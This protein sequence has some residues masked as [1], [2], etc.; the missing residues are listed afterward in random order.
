MVVIV[1]IKDDVGYLSPKIS[2]F[3]HLPSYFDG[4]LYI[5]LELSYWRFLLHPSRASR[6]LTYF[7]CHP[8][9]RFQHFNK[10]EE[11]HSYCIE[12]DLDIHFHSLYGNTI[13]LL[14]VRCSEDIILF[15]IKIYSVLVCRCV[16]SASRGKGGMYIG[17]KRCLY[18]MVNNIQVR[19]LSIFM[20]EH[21]CVGVC[22]RYEYVKS[23]QTHTHK[24][25]CAAQCLQHTAITAQYRG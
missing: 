1:V 22:E 14:M 24:V 18:T 3:Y 11:L 21:C 12:P 6:S 23:K 5:L 10:L 8:S 17:G 7:I 15:L 20:G 9:K 19:F 16:P 2:L 13:Y 25:N 4:K